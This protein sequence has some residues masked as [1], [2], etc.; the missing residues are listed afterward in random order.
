[1]ESIFEREVRVAPLA[2]ELIH[3]IGGVG[4]NKFEPFRVVQDDVI[5]L[6]WGESF[7]NVSVSRRQLYRASCIKLDERPTQLVAQEMWPW[8]PHR[9]LQTEYTIDQR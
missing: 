8:F 2:D 9:T 1:M 3:V 4:I 5:V 6:G 7:V